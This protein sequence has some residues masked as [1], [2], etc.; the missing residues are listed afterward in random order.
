MYS[1]NRNLVEYDGKTFISEKRLRE[2]KRR[3]LRK[4]RREF[5]QPVAMYV[6]EAK[7]Q[8]FEKPKLSFHDKNRAIDKFDKY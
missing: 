4:A 7:K 8:S 5:L 3:E 6:G 2:Y 1:I